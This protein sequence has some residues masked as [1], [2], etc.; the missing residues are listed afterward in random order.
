MAQSCRTCATAYPQLAKAE[1]ASQA[2]PL[3]NPF[4]SVLDRSSSLTVTDTTRPSPFLLDDGAAAG[5][6]GVEGGEM[7]GDRVEAAHNHP[8]AFAARAVRFRQRQDATGS[9]A[10][11]EARSPAETRR[12]YSRKSK[13]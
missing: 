2:H 4:R 10:D 3:V 5:Q 6:D 8:L 9:A 13:Y 12:A 11:H 1:V 7:S